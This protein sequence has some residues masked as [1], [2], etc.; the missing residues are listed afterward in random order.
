MLTKIPFFREIIISYFECK[1]CGHRNNAIDSAG[2]IAPQGERIAV[3]CRSASDLN[4][5]IVKSDTA[6]VRVPEI[7]LEI[8]ATRR[9]AR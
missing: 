5:T 3:R 7:A 4:R 8:P 6:T 1:H 2:R 9:R